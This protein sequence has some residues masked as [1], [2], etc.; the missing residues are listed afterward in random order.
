MWDLV[1]TWME[2]WE[3]PGMEPRYLALGAQSLS[4]WTTGEVS[5][6]IFL[7]LPVDGHLGCYYLLAVMNKAI[8]NIDIQVFV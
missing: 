7:I 3:P 4:H 6:H 1:P 5:Y 8:M 2:P